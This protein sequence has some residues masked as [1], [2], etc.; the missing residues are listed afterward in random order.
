[1]ADV[2]G[3]IEA[4][5][6]SLQRKEY[7]PAAWRGRLTMEEGYRAQLGLL[8]RHIAMGERQAGWK[9]G[10]TSRATREQIG[11]HEP[12]M[13]F[14]LGGAQRSSGISLPFAS[15][16]GPCVENEL[17]LTLGRTLR[18]P[19]VTTTQARAAL[20]RVAP[21]FEL[22]EWRGE[23]AGD[24]PLA[25]TDNCQ[26]TMFITGDTLSLPLDANLA[27]TELEVWVNGALAE[28]ASG[29][30][31]MGDPAASVAWLANKLAEFGLTLEA[32]MQ[33][34]SGSFTKQVRLAPGM[35]VEARFTPFGEVVASFP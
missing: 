23:F 25:L 27:E 13:G 26:Q 35:R 20:S 9:V 34:M 30:E 1:V 10:L 28:R 16:M 17:C 12:V 15:L 2:E 7:F 19:G 32:G 6:V 8:A 3:A 24:L 22:V 18:G 29:Q 14:L 21:A 11:V 33:V 5:W 31:V 4:L